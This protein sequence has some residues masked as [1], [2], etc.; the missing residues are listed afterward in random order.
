[1]S[2]LEGRRFFEYPPLLYVLSEKITLSLYEKKLN[3]IK[4]LAGYSKKNILLD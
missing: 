1:M 2:E 4:F 3:R